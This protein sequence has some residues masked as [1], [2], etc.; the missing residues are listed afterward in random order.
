MYIYPYDTFVV[1]KVINLT[2]YI[3]D[4]YIEREKYAFFRL[5]LMLTTDIQ[6]HKRLLKNLKKLVIMVLVSII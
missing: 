5:I 4:I 1:I 3:I 2:L 6:V